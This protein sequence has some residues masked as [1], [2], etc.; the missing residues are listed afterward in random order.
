VNGEE[1]RNRLGR[2]PRVTRVVGAGTLAIVLAGGLLF[3]RAKSQVN[4]IPLSADAKLVTAVAAKASTFRPS[5]TYV[6]TLEPWVEAKV[7]PQFVSA[8]VE[9]VRVRPGAVVKKGDV[10]AT[11]DCR[12][13]SALDKA[14]AAQAAAV[15]TMQKAISHEARRI[16]ELGPGG[17]VSPNEIE[18]KAAESE[19]KQ[20]QYLSLEAQRLESSLK[21]NDCVLRAPFDGEIIDRMKDPGAFVRPG[22]AIV[23][24]VDRNTVRLA[25]DVPEDDFAAVEPEAP[26]R[27]RVISTGE[28]LVR[29]ITRRA[30]GAEPTTRTVHVEIDIPNPEHRLPVY[31]TAEVTV[32]VGEAVPATEVPLAAAIVRGKKADA[33]VVS[34]GRA[35]L[36][37]V[38]VL[39]ETK[40][41]LFVAR[42]LAPGSLVVLEGRTLLGDGDRVKLK[43]QDAPARDV[44]EKANER[45]EG[46]P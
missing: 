39:G 23:T 24:A 8:Y 30:P 28:E 15:Q 37:T 14:I 43:R 2:V 34:D 31:T 32:D 44:A 9:T 6:G 11:L 4:K 41:R 18:Q 22:E 20:S 19:S 25:T 35:R 3:W 1:L 33:F 5:R 38:A 46:N 36:T 17:F 29:P 7:G 42:S 10:L 26:A 13:V 40:G 27:I 16:S 45:S 21:V 12:N